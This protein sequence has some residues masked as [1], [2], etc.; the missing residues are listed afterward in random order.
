MKKSLFIL[1]AYFATSYS[2]AQNKLEASGNIGLGTSNPVA[3]LSVTP[4]QSS[5][6]GANIATTFIAGTFSVLGNS[7]GSYLYPFEFQHSN[8]GNIDRLQFA[9]YRRIAG[10]DWGGTA[11]RMQF[12]VDNS[13][14]EGS[15]AF[16]EIGA[17]DPNIA[18]GGSI[19][20]GTALQDRLVVTN[21]GYVGINTVNPKE[22]LSVNGKIR[23]KEV[24]VE[25]S[26]WPDYVFDSS[27][28]PDSLMALEQDIKL[29]KHL[30]NVPSASEVQ[31]DG[32]D[33]G[34]LGATLLEKIEELTLHMID[35]KKENQH[36]KKELE[37][38]KHSTK[39]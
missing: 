31:Q 4:I 29:K 33:L 36:L 20:L 11:Y 17:S 35:L 7:A 2:Y 8:T 37:A 3:A 13:F 1:I 30:P 27:Y 23:A 6:P 15:K 12:A 9:P 34:K 39:Q 22:Q 26:N 24:K 16:S 25:V 5:G 21:D 18:G 14:T 10:P 19:S 28:S 38:I 32:V